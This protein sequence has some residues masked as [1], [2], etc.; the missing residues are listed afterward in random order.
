MEIFMDLTTS[1]MI[2]ENTEPNLSLDEFVRTATSKIKDLAQHGVLDATLTGGVKV[3]I[4]PVGMKALYAKEGAELVVTPTHIQVTV[5]NPNTAPEDLVKALR[6]P[7]PRRTQTIAGAM[8]GETQ[9]QFSEL[10][11]SPKNNEKN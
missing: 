2:E 4:D 11:A 9:Q 7:E 5:T 8:I 6:K 10:E 3:E 1:L